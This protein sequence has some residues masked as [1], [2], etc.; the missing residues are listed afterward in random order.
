[1]ESGFVTLTS[2]TATDLLYFKNTGSPDISVALYVVITGASTGGTGDAVLGILFDPHT[3]SV[4]DLIG[5]AINANPINTKVGDTAPPPGDYFI[6]EE[7]DQLT[8]H[9]NTLGSATTAS[10]RLLLSTYT[11]V[12]QGKAIAMRITPPSGNTSMVC[13]MIMEFYQEDAE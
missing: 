6:G 12:P 10:A 2:D 1:M 8:G 7:G 11:V 9:Y 5:G 4:G 13:N 3:D